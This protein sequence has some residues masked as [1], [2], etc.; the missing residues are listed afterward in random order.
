MLYEY[1]FYLILN[2]LFIFILRKKQIKEIKRK[3]FASKSGDGG[4]K[5]MV[6]VELKFYFAWLRL[7]WCNP[8]LHGHGHDSLRDKHAQGMDSP[9]RGSHSMWMLIIIKTFEQ[10]ISLLTSLVYIA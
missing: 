5:V 1:F 4:I 8:Q 10:L 7:Y 9:W 2:L 3:N 6:V